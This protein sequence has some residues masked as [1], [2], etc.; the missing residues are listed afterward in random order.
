MQKTGKCG[1]NPSSITKY[2]KN[3]QP[4]TFQQLRQPDYKFYD[5]TFPPTRNSLISKN[6][7][8]EFVDR[9]RGPNQLKE[10]EEDIP[11]GADRLVWKRVTDIHPKW[12][13]FEGKIE[14]NDVQQGSL[15]DCYFLSSITALTE[16]PYLIKEKLKTFK[17][18][19]E[20]YYEVIFFIDGEWQIVFLD[21]Y[22]PYD[23]KRKQFAFAIDHIIMN[24]GQCYQKR[25]RQN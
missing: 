22:F 13:V 20:G 23:P 21:D 8:D 15:G 17:F 12:E 24:Y 14:F 2:W 18:N 5:K 25:H 7:Y 16:Y 3:L 19:Q 10:F 11:G 9:K 1:I 4:P 6:Q